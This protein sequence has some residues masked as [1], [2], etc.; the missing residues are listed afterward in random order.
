[1]G[2]GHLP[3]Q[4]LATAKKLAQKLKKPWLAEL[5]VELETDISALISDDSLYDALADDLNAFAKKTPALRSFD[6]RPAI[7]ERLHT[8]LADEA[9]FIA[10]T[11][12]MMNAHADWKAMNLLRT[13]LG[14][15]AIDRPTAEETA[16]NRARKPFKKLPH[17]L[18]ISMTIRALYQGNPKQRTER[19]RAT[20]KK[21][22][23]VRQ[24][25]HGGVGAGIKAG[26]R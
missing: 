23:A 19:G 15:L 1:M 18:Q 20:L 8:L 14:L 12:R 3:Y 22:V 5:R 2:I 11:G 4:D 7:V 9:L 24:S 26:K 6:L 17:W 16:R 10:L 13:A 25:S 21:R